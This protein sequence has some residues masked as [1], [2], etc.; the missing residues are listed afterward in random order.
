ML[1]IALLVPVRAAQAQAPVVSHWGMQLIVG[2]PSGDLKSESGANWGGGLGVQYTQDLTGTGT[3]LLRPRVEFLVI[4][5]SL[6]GGVSGVNTSG[7][8]MVDGQYFLAHD[9]DGFYL[10]AGI[11]ANKAS[12]KLQSFD[13]YG[14]QLAATVSGT[15]A[16]AWEVGAGYNFNNHWGVEARYLGTNLSGNYNYALD[17]NTGSIPGFSTSSNSLW[18]AG[19]WRF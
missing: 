7:S 19:T 12:Y 5:G 9:Q 4:P 15:L 16:F 6:P 18:L 14:D 2:A 3:Y 17:G 13:Q 1:A 11:G 8:L 10:L